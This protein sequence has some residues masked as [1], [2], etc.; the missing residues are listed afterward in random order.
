MWS[1]D[2]NCKSVEILKAIVGEEAKYVFGFLRYTKK[3]KM[4]HIVSVFESGSDGGRRK[5]ILAVD[6]GY[7]VPVALSIHVTRSRF[8][9]IPCDM[10]WGYRLL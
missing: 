10:S 3:R 8:L 6:I 4:N 7:H 9:H 1:R 2:Q 5:N